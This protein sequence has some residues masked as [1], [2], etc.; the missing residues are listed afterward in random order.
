MIYVIDDDEI[1]ADCIAKACGEK[2]EIHM[3]SNAIEAVRAI[4]AAGT[5]DLIF[6]DILLDGPDGFTLLNELASYEDTAKI[7]VVVVSSLNF[8]ERDLKAY[9]VVGV[10]DKG[11]MMP[12]EIKQYVEEY[13]D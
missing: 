10:L 3:F 7:P 12:L 9:G 11:T 6:L 8:K 5:P 4:D 2:N 13:C 1:M